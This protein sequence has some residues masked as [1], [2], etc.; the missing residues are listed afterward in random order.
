V[1]VKLIA[2]LVILTLLRPSSFTAETPSDEIRQF[3]RQLQSSDEQVRCYAA[4]AL[5]KK[6]AKAAAAVPLLI[7]ALDDKSAKVREH[8]V[9]ALGDIGSHA[10]EAVP[11]LLSLL[12]DCQDPALGKL[13]A[14]AL[15]EVGD[16]DLVV[17][18]ILDWS[19]RASTRRAATFSAHQVATS[20]ILGLGYKAHPALLAALKHKDRRAA[21]L[22]VLSGMDDG[23]APFYATLAQ[24]K[25]PAFAKQAVDALSNL[26]DA[27]MPGLVDA[28]EHPDRSI[29]E[30]ARNALLENARL[31]RIDRLDCLDSQQAVLALAALLPMTRSRVPDIRR[32]AFVGVVNYGGPRRPEALLGL[33]DRDAQV[34][35]AVCQALGCWGSEAK[36]K[37]IP[38][39]E[40]LQD[41]D[42]SVRLSREGMKSNGGVLPQRHVREAAGA[43]RL[44]APTLTS[45]YFARYTNGLRNMPPK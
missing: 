27:A 3:M 42:E 20:V 26:G 30:Q 45:C 18:R 19:M 44:A 12:A 35:R 28:L 40:C 15:A 21:A 39:A 16:V 37:L 31:R 1:R 38:L 7:E 22:T 24:D 5:G 8:A 43:A 11:A 13:A 32:R 36:T 33:R 14:E 25:D 23:A 6:R 17:P 34:R 41:A 9:V 29:R 2:G 10:S 4:Y